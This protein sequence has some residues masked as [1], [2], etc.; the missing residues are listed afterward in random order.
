M[1]TTT[2]K[3]EVRTREDYLLLYRLYHIAT[4]KI[5]WRIAC[6]FFAVFILSI[7]SFFNSIKQRENP[8]AAAAAAEAEAAA[9]AAN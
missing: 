9:A 7:S 1:M 8:T 3:I 6:K 2:I 5:N 4:R